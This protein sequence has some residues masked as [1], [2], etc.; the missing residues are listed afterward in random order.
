MCHGTADR[1]VAGEQK[2]GW[3]LGCCREVVVDGVP[4]LLRQLELTRATRLPLADCRSIDCVAMR[5]HVL[6]LES[7]HVAPR[8]LLSIAMARSRVRPSTINRVLMD[9]TC[10]GRSGGLAPISLPYSMA[11]G[12]GP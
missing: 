5:R 6:N 10:F 4:R 3:L 12:G 7:H 1:A 2:F 8:S 11:C 9:Q